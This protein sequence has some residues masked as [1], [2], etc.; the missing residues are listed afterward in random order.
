[1]S[2]AHFK[3]LDPK[4]ELLFLKRAL[5][6]L[7]KGFYVGGVEGIVDELFGELSLLHVFFGSSP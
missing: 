3:P 2:P 7:E 6:F 5:E 1:M 4:A